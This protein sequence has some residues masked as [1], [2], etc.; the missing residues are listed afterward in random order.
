MFQVLIDITGH[1]FPPPRRRC[2]RKDTCS[3][4]DVIDL[5]EDDPPGDIDV[6]KPSPTLPSVESRDKKVHVTPTSFGTAQE[7]QSQTSVDKD[8]ANSGCFVGSS[9][10]PFASESL[11][12]ENTLTDVLQRT[13]RYF[14][15]DTHCN[16]SL[17]SEQPSL[18]KS[19]EHCRSNDKSK[20]PFK[21]KS[22]V[23]KDSIADVSQNTKDTQLSTQ[24]VCSIE[25]DQVDNLDSLQKYRD[26]ILS[27]YSPDSPYYCP[28]E[29]DAYIFSDSS[30]K[31]E[32]NS[33]LFTHNSQQSFQTSELPSATHTASV[34]NAFSLKEDDEMMNISKN[35]NLYTRVHPEPSC[36]SIPTS[37][38]ASPPRSPELL[39]RHSKPNSPTSTEILAS[40]TAA[41]SPDL[42]TL[43]SPS[44]LLISQ[45]SSPNFPERTEQKRNDIDAGSLESPP[46]RL[47]ETSSDDGN[48]NVLDNVESGLSENNTENRQHICLT[49]YKKFNRC[50]SGTVPH[51][52]RCFDMHIDF[53]I[54]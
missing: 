43:S 2:S 17:P 22:E 27:P 8:V 20:N 5:S 41:H 1:N 30:N 16:S 46:I 53:Y 40:D 47:W 45:P 39:S 52:V 25:A 33:H 49:Q 35:E 26:R 31:S 24:A 21:Y 32:D 3:S 51:M 34:S 13:E 15:Q 23:L 36:P 19:L 44:S 38:R 12:Q 6:Q 50:M 10:Q 37:S 18:D 54:D 48:E 4:L 29:V 14:H 42:S 9:V 7:S 28:S 11:S